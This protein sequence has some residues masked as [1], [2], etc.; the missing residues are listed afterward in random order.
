[1]AIS[2]NNF[3]LFP[4]TEPEQG[5][6]TRRKWLCSHA[7]KIIIQLDTS[8]ESPGEQMNQWWWWVTR[9]EKGVE[10]ERA[11]PTDYV[12]ESNTTAYEME[13]VLISPLVGYWDEALRWERRDFLLDQRQFSQPSAFVLSS[14][15]M[16]VRKKKKQPSTIDY[17]SP[18]QQATIEPP[19]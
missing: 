19:F 14:C 16:N 5:K 12:S 9:R 11:R 15:V 2:D 7:L 10:L 17:K 18:W 1:M 13:V 8:L 6:G 4:A 3:L